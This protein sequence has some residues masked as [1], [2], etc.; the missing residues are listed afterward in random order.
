MYKY[1]CTTCGRISYS[2]SRPEVQLDDR[3]KYPGCNGK[4]EMEGDDN[5]GG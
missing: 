4:V 3:C 5:N 1:V 2:A